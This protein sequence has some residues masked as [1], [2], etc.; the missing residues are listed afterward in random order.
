MLA[1]GP[2]AVGEAV[3]LVLGGGEGGL[4]LGDGSSQA[5]RLLGRGVDGLGLGQQPLGLVVGVGGFVV[6]GLGG[7]DAGLALGNGVCELLLLRGGLG[8]AAVQRAPDE[9]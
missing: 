2:L 4:L 6:G 7:L 1:E 5:A 9:E 3:E 8:G